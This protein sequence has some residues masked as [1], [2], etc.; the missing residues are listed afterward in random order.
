MQTTL[1]PIQRFWK[2]LQPDQREIRNVYVYA[3]FNGLINL[4][5]PLGVQAIVNLIQGG[6]INTSWI[7]LVVIV[8]IGVGV[9]G[10][11]QIFQLR[12][13]E[14]LQQKIFTRAAFEF[15]YR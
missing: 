1:L 9:S 11:L 15:A 3:I 8:V 7:V 13:V 5:L 10:A 14:D 4:S 6:A 2:L 12:I